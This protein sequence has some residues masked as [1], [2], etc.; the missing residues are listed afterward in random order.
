MQSYEQ[1]NGFSAMSVD[2]LYFING[3]SVQK[4]TL[5]QTI[6]NYMD[7]FGEGMQDAAVVTAPIIGAAPGGDKLLA[8][9]AAVGYVVEKVGEALSK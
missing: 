2:E 6:G 3:G 1:N 5:S 7:K 8:G 9:Y 4:P